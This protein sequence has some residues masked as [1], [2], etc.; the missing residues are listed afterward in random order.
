[1]MSSI[2]SDKPSNLGRMNEFAAIINPGMQGCRIE[3]EY[4]AKQIRRNTPVKV[5]EVPYDEFIIH[6]IS[7]P[8][9]IKALFGK[10]LEKIEKP[11]F[12]QIVNMFSSAITRKR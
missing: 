10:M 11:Y 6:Y 8:G 4:Y 3:H 12:T 1:M 7:F 2:T 5:R 9:L